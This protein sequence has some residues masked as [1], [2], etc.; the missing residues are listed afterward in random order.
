MNVLGKSIYWLSILSILTVSILSFIFLGWQIGVAVLV[1]IPAFIIASALSDKI[2]ISRRDRYTKSEWSVFC[3]KI[4]WS[5]GIAIIV[6]AVVYI[7]LAYNFG[8]PMGVMP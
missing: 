4:G 3:K 8:D 7:F 5:W 2:A 1:A 6:F